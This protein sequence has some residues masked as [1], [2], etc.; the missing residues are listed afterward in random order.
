MTTSRYAIVFRT[1]VT[2]LKFDDNETPHEMKKKKEKNFK[3]KT[4]VQF[5]SFSFSITI[6]I[7]Q[8]VYLGFQTNT[9]K[10]RSFWK[11]LFHPVTTT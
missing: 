6:V 1:Y 8:M 7:R 4:I 2:I 5:F 10:E 11:T 3:I 9:I